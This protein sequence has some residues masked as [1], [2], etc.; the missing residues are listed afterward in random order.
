MSENRNRRIRRI[1]YTFFKKEKGT[2][3]SFFDIMQKNRCK[4]C[5]LLVNDAH[6]VWRITLTERDTEDYNK[7]EQS[8]TEFHREKSRSSIDLKR[9]DCGGDEDNI[10]MVIKYTQK[11][12]K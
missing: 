8:L 4:N 9:Y 5:A 10:Q 6:K 11:E 12:P 3:F 7:K 2:P 1:K